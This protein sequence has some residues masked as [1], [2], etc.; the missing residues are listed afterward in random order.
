MV[1]FNVCFLN[2]SREMGIMVASPHCVFHILHLLLC[3]GAL[4]P[5]RH[6]FGLHIPFL[7]MLSLKG[8]YSFF[9]RAVHATIVKAV[10]RL[11]LNRAQ[12]C[13]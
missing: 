9:G 4:L 11:L 6:R 7:C 13:E 10:A 8:V 1:Y 5:N 3:Q 2:L 12:L